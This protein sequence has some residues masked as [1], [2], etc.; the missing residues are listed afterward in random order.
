MSNLNAIAQ[1]IKPNFK[2]LSAFGAVVANVRSGGAFDQKMT[3]NGTCRAINESCFV[4]VMIKILPNSLSKPN[5]VDRERP[6][7][8][9]SVKLKL[10]AM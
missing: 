1:L 10:K 2:K 6:R 7:F 4:H 3:A 9:R 5:R 8:S